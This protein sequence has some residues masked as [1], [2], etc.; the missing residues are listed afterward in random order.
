MSDETSEFRF[1]AGQAEALGVA[2]M[3]GRRG[4]TDVAG[5]QVSFLEWGEADP[6]TVF[7]HGI[8]LN[9]HTFDA[10]VFALGRSAVVLDLPG[11]GDSTWRDD[12]DYRPETIAPAVLA[13]LDGLPRQRA[14]L[15]IGQSLGAM[16]AVAVEALRP[17]TASGVV[18]IDMSPGI[19]AGD[20]AQ[21][22]GFLAGPQKFAS[23]DEIVDRALE[24]G[25]GTS[26]QQLA[27]GV[28]LNTR[29]LDGG[30]VIWKHHV[31]NL[32]E[33]VEMPSADF[34]RWWP[35]LEEATAPV[36]LVRG[37]SGYLSQEV[38]DDF[39]RRVPKAEIAELATGH[40]VHEQDPAGLAALI[41]E[42]SARHSL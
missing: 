1:A 29:V 23:R 40:N 4:A 2:A 3:A 24:H 20:A 12:A 36:L 35:V 14:R 26:R 15:L 21:V 33:G 11:H 16:T 30:S 37:T 8:G 32:P 42:W 22:R 28:E 25:I 31:A 38:V 9:A 27:R 19:R 13:V 18:L 7:L 6:E 5:R 17:G 10:T 34:S 41:A 39:R